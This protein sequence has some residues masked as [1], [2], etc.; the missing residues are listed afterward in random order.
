MRRTVTLILAVCL[1]AACGSPPPSSGTVVE[2]SYDDP[3]SIPV[4]S[5]SPVGKTTVC[6]TTWINDGPHWRLL[7]DGDSEHGWVS[8]D[9]ATWDSL[10]VG[11]H[12]EEMAS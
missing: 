12:Y 9:P 3:D 4:T 1:I 10:H 6:H 11:D 8:V 7:I 5:C 2:K